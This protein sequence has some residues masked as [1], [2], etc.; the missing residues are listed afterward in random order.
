M[1]KWLVAINTQATA[2]KIEVGHGRYHFHVSRDSRY[3]WHLD[4]TRGMKFSK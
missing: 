4:K 2:V 3:L 1:G